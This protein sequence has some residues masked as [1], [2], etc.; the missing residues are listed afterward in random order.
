[1]RLL[2]I[3]S[4]RAEE[5]IGT[6][7]PYAIL[8]HTWGADEVTL[9]D[10]DHLGLDDK[11]GWK[12]IIGFAR[13]I[14]Q[15]NQPVD[16]FWVDTCC[17]DKSSSAEL[18]E[19]INSMFHWYRESVC[20]FAYLADVEWRAHSSSPLGADFESSKWFTRGWTLQELL[21]PRDLEFFDKDWRGIGN[22]HDLMERISTRTNID[23]DTLRLGQWPNASVAMRMSW[24]AGRQT[25][26]PEDMAYCLLGIF[27]VNM[28]LLYGEGDRAFTRLQEEI[29]KESEDQ[30]IFA[31]VLMWS[32]IPPK[33]HR[34]SLPAK[35]SSSI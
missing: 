20:C 7:P 29:L 22:R 19:A 27:D 33:V 35:E 16:Y 10:L 31:I 21:A 2:N 3:R 18:S 26:R 5:F 23:T 9:H 32:L 12:K 6:P 15:S 28:P 11:P 4:L 25:T 14:R 30:S 8:S 17:I 24:A 1:M 13:A 34:W